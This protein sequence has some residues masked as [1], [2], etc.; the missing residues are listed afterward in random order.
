MKFSIIT[1][2][3]DS[4]RTIEKTVNSVLIQKNV[5]VEHIIKDA[6]S[7]DN[8]IELV[9]SANPDALIFV[10]KDSGIYDA[11]NMG[12]KEATGDIVAFLNSDDHYSHGNVLSSVHSIFMKTNS[13]FVYGDI[14]MVDDKG[15]AVREWRTGKIGPKGLL[16]Q[17]IP[18][19]AFFVRKEILDAISPP[20]DASY[21]IAADLKQQLIIVNKMKSKGQ[22]I[23]DIL[24]IMLV[25]GESTNNINSYFRGWG[26]S[27]RAY[28]ETLGNGSYWY[29]FMKVFSKIK[30]L[31]FQRKVNDL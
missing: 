17:Q 11:M 13:D 15:N 2:T 16:Y 4:S 25:G 20:F 29:V 21:R 1:I 5:D 26:E 23:A 9:K 6:Q 28:R 19:P 14:K 12:Y 24:T 3:K 27:S 8:T 10:S 18:H 22:Y 31:R 30:G 7:T